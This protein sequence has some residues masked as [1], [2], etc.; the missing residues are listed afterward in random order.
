MAD[1]QMETILIGL[2]GFGL[3]LI[4]DIQD[5]VETKIITVLVAQSNILKNSKAV[6]KIE[7]DDNVLSKIQEV[8]SIYKNIIVAN[9]LGGNSSK[10]LMQIVGMLE[11]NNKNTEVIVT[12]PFS[13]E[14]KEKNGLSDSILNKLVEKDINIRVYENDTVQNNVGEN[15]S[16]KEAFKSYHKAIGEYIIEKYTK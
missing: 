8:V 14:A 6:C 5:D 7:L 11:E 15:I 2:G 3:N 1:K 16:T 12:K 4:N 9:G 13:W 10:Y